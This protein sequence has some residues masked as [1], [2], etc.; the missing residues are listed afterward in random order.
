MEKSAV[1][2]LIFMRPFSVTKSSVWLVS[3]E[4]RPVRGSKPRYRSLLHVSSHSVV[5]LQN[6][7]HRKHNDYTNP[8]LAML[9]VEKT[10]V[11]E[12]LHVVKSSGKCNMWP[13]SR[14]EPLDGT[15]CHQN[16]VFYIRKEKTKRDSDICVRSNGHNI[17]A[18]H[19]TVL[20]KHVLSSRDRIEL[21]ET[22]YDTWK[23]K[24]NLFI[25]MLFFLNRN[26]IV[27]LFMYIVFQID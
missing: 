26:R 27:S 23:Q 25:H 15:V 20:T 12:C 4:S 19:D 3:K 7:T 17:P 18:L 9:W 5:S 11:R 2:P 6:S 1:D 24:Q 13:V 10:K 16:W 22:I 21:G 14:Q 8:V